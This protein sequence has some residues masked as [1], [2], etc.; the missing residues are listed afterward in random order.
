MPEIFIKQGIDYSSPSLSRHS[1]TGGGPLICSQAT[2]Q[3]RKAITSFSFSHMSKVTMTKSQA[4]RV[5]ISDALLWNSPPLGGTGNVES[6]KTVLIK[7][8]GRMGGPLLWLQTNKQN[9]QNKN[10]SII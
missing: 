10:G 7:R 3:L 4:A 9:I 2:G 8:R 1:P 5:N 6:V